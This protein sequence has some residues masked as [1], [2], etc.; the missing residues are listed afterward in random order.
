TRTLDPA[1]HPHHFMSF[2]NEP[3]GDRRADQ[4]GCAD[5]EN[6]LRLGHISVSRLAALSWNWSFWISWL[7]CP[8]SPECCFLSRF[9]STWFSPILSFGRS[10]SAPTPARLP[11]V[12]GPSFF[13]LACAI[14]NSSV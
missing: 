10:V 8:R 4:S 2:R 1:R 11:C 7:S 6:P 13:L 9:D 14:L 12:P 5:D 3:S